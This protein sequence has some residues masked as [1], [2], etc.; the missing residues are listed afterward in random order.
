MDFCEHPRE[1]KELM[2]IVKHAA[3]MAGVESLDRG[4]TKQN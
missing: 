3:E 1:D 4:E 2:F